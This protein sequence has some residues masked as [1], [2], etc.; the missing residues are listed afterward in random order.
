[1]IV[2]H[3]WSL[4]R[5]SGA[6]ILLPFLQFRDNYSSLHVAISL[7]LFKGFLLATSM[8]GTHYDRDSSAIAFKDSHLS[9]M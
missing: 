9:L 8:S 5:S 7:C 2:G 6:A 4:E 3:M 1:M